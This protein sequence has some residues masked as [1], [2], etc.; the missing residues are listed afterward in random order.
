MLPQVVG[1]GSIFIDDIVLPTGETRMGMLGGGV[2][3]ALMGMV[4]WDE[5]PA[6]VGLIGQGLPETAMHFIHKHLDTRGLVQLP[7]PQA[8]AWQLFEED[9][10]RTEVPRVTN[11][12]PFIEG[13]TPDY[14]PESYRGSTAFYLL[15][16]FEGIRRWRE[17][18]EGIILWEPLQQLMLAENRLA[19]HQAL[20]HGDID[21]VSPNLIE[22]Q[23]IYGHLP[24]YDLIQAMFDDGANIVALRMG[25]KG[26][27]IADKRTGEYHIIPSI[28]VTITDI[29][30]AG[31]TYCGAFVLG[32]YRGKSLLEAGCMATVAAS[33]CIE[34]NGVLN[35]EKVDKM[36]RDN[37]YMTLIT[38]VTM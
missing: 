13:P 27:C 22:A 33:F 18:I 32:L 12:A 30:G 21:V 31:N 20:S 1:I 29:T 37:R 25:E 9:G 14:L 11:I 34:Q 10:R 24:P 19:M 8:R 23:A 36:E 35:P 4:L 7:I 38:Q 26:S 16:G 15:Q 2:L 6:I 3:H 28:P 17:C 5:R